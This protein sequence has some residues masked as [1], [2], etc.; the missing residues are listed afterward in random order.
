M[1]SRNSSTVAASLPVLAQQLLHLHYPFSLPRPNPLAKPSLSVPRELMMRPEPS[2]IHCAVSTGPLRSA[3]RWEGPPSCCGLGPTNS[4]SR[5]KMVDL[6][7]KS[8]RLNSSH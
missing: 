2:P 4:L 8:T 1:G 6:D 5:S 7:R 3:A